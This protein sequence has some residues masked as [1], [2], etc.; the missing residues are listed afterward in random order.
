MSINQIIELVE[1]LRAESHRL[2]AL[3][4]S[5]E[6]PTVDALRDHRATAR[7]RLDRER[8]FWVGEYKEATRNIYPVVGHGGYW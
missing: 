1:M 8:E 7:G 4:W 2:H 6:G 3:M 5:A